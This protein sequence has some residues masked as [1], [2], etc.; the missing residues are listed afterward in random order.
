MPQLDHFRPPLGRQR[1]WESFHSLWA[2][3]MV[4]DLN[5]TLLPASYVAEP[6]V[7]LGVEIEVDVATLREDGHTR[8]AD[9]SAVATAVYAPPQ[10]GLT[11]QA[12]F[13]D[14]DVF[15][16]KVHKEE[17]GLR[18]V[19]A[20]ELVSPRNKDRPGA[21]AAFVR[22]CAAYLQQGVALIVVDIVTERTG[23][24]H[25]DLVRLLHNAAPDLA[26]PQALYAV[27]YRARPSADS[28][29]MEA[30]PHRL[31]LGEPLPT[32]PLWLDVDLAIGMDLDETYRATCDAL[33]IA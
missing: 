16:I 5:L 27:A 24:L 22:K 14:S 4:R 8:Q 13:G 11:F 10:P 25:A 29:H 3:E 6:N 32:L 33:R 20:I 15:E 19:A 7:K 31:A 12:D 28:T 17:G 18:L 2:G 23:N 9:S 26:E 21:R 1:H 30:W